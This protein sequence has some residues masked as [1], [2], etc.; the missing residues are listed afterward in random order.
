VNGTYVL[1]DDED[2]D[3]VARPLYKQQ[4][5]DHVIRYDERGWDPELEI[6]GAWL[7]QYDKSDRDILY[8]A[9]SKSKLSPPT[10]TCTETHCIWKLYEGCDLETEELEPTPKVCCAA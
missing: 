7:I 8:C 4:D 3:Y 9:P 2:P 5:G 1:L 6:V 10:C